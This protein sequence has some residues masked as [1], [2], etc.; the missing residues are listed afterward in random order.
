VIPAFARK[1]DAKKYAAKCCVEWLMRERY[2]PSDGNNVVFQH[3]AVGVKYFTPDS[4][5]EP[6]GMTENQDAM[7]AGAGATANAPPPA[8]ARIQ[9]LVAAQIADSGGVRLDEGDATNAN[10]GNNVNG[11]ASKKAGASEVDVHDED[12]PITKRVEA[13]CRRLGLVMPRYVVT[14]NPR[15]GN[16]FDGYADFGADACRI[17]DEV[18]RSEFVYSKSFTKLAIAEKVLKRLLLIEAERS[19]GFETLIEAER[20]EGVA[21]LIDDVLR[22]DSP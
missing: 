7:G 13:M 21:T 5:Q 20:S 10:R 16:Y 22:P 11:N 1:K 17:P 18:G 4:A 19:E 3:G 2:M 6:A 14:A 9:E 12:V 8:P 15:D